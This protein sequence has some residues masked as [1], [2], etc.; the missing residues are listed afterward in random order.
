MS[1]ENIKQEDS[2]EEIES[3]LSR[4]E[5]FIENNQKILTIIV[6]A[7]VIIVGG[8]F[9]FQKLYIKP[10]EAEAQSQMFPAEIYFEK[11][12]FKL[13]LNG[14]GKNLGF[15]SIIEDYGMTK[16]ANLASYYS[17]ICYLNMGQFQN[18]IDNLKDFDSDDKML[19][20]VAIGAIGDAYIELGQKEEGISYYLKAADNTPNT[21]TTPIYLMK[22]GNAYE[23]IGKYDKALEIYQRLEKEYPASNEGRKVEKY[24]ERSKVK[25]NL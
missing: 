4:T 5:N 13:A 21:F 2:F 16:T 19:T 18:A 8:Y 9:A 12:S 23:N 14:D 6:A 22:A 1:K 11:D 7:I 25:G 17:G 3:A 15:L 24:I 20:P 10:L